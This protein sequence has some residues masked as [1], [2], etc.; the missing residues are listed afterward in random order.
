MAIAFLTA[1]V[2]AIGM[3][4]K[5]IPAAFQMILEEAFTMRAG[6]SGVAG[7]G[8]GT[9][10]KK[11]IA[12]GV[13]TNEAGLGSS[14]MVNAVADV[15]EPVQQGM[16]AIF[17]VFLDT[18]V[19]CTLTALIILTSGVYDRTSYNLAIANGGLEYLPDGAVLTGKAFAASFGVRGEWFVAVC[20]VCFAFATILAWSYY[21]ERAANYLF[22]KKI[23]VFYQILFLGALFSGSV[24][25][26]TIV[27]ELS[28]LWN[29]MMAIPN[30]AA[31]AIL[32]KDVIKATR[33]YIDG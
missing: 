9:A 30:L 24:M 6:V 12:R 20:I 22:G 17:A 2:L 28:D 23:R 18:F 4:I 13:F 19:M 16:W 31:V 3:H 21:G 33:R 11:G 14:V 5:Q 10:I 25:K 8:I 1:S 15:K 29:A 26:L 7:Y 27:W 32:S